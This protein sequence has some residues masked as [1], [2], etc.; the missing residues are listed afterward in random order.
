MKSLPVE[1]QLN[2]LKYLNY[3]QL[4]SIQQSNGYFNSLI[5][6]YKEELAIKSFYSMH[7]VSWRLCKFIILIFGYFIFNL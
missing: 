1:V 2:I 6:K 4:N 3:N 5:N 7:L